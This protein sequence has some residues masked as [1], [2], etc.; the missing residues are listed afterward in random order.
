MVFVA[1]MQSGTVDNQERGEGN[2]Y[3]VYNLDYVREGAM[4]EVSEVLSL[5]AR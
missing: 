1:D 4:P 3:A 2:Y 5:Q